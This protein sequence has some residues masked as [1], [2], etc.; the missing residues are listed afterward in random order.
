MLVKDLFDLAPLIKRSLSYDSL[1]FIAQIINLSVIGTT[2][3]AEV[4]EVDVDDE[5]RLND[6]AFIFADVFRTQLHLACLD[7]VAALDESS[8]K[9]HAEH[10]LVREASVAKDDLDISLE[11]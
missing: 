1:A 11:D 2:R 9:H 8:V 5:V 6:L 7:I 10:C 4:V 3:R